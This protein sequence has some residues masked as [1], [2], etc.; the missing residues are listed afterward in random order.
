MKSEIATLTNKLKLK[1]VEIKTLKESIA[2]IATMELDID[3]LTNQLNMKEI[4]IKTLKES[5]AKNTTNN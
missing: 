2:K 1:D 5:I 3:T 4:E